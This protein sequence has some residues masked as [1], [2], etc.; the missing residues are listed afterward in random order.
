MLLV[1]TSVWVDH[2]RRGNARLMAHL[3]AGEVLTHP[4]VLGELACGNL[5]NRK[6]VLGLL[7]ALPAA[8]LVTDEE[9]LAFLDNEKLYGRG[10]AWVDVHLL[11]SARLSGA[12]LWSMDRAL[13]SAAKA[14][15]LAAG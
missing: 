11:A 6:E 2:L 15:G 9:A 14:L 3:S 4:D 1:D 5:V 13:A 12:G 10:L 7:R 8:N